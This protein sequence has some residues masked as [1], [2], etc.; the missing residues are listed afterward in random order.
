MEELLRVLRI[1]GLEG[2]VVDEDVPALDAA[3]A[4][5]ED[6]ATVLGTQKRTQLGVYL[7]TRRWQWQQ[8]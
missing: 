3:E 6:M 1:E 7:T 5:Q 8:L 2:E 4:I